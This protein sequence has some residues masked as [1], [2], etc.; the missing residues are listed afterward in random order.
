VETFDVRALL[1][2]TAAALTAERRT[3]D[4]LAVYDALIA[5]W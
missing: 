2:P 3:P 5:S 4:Q 1:E